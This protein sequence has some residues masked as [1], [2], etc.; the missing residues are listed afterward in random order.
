MNEA[1][2]GALGTLSEQDKTQL[3]RL[4][5]AVRSSHT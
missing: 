5:D 2:D 3:I 1:D 4:L